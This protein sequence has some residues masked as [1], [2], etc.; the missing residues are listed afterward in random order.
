[1]ADGM[2]ALLVGGAIGVGGTILGTLLSQWMSRKTAVE[3][4]RQNIAGQAANVEKTIAAQLEVSQRTVDAQLEVSR[5]TV[6]TQ[7]A[8][9]QIVVEGQR[10]KE[11]DAALRDRRSAL[12]EPL[13]S[14]VNKRAGEFNNLSEAIALKDW[15]R[16][17]DL[18]VAL[19]QVSRVQQTLT[20]MMIINDQPVRRAVAAFLSAETDLWN[21][22]TQC[23]KTPHPDNNSLMGSAQADF[24]LAHAELVR[25]VDGFV[26]R[27]SDLPG[28]PI[29][30]SEI[31]PISSVRFAHPWIENPASP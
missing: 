4:A 7:L 3:V 14:G 28:N 9:A 10:L 31:V 24:V 5:R 30:I 1:M 16:A 15:G 20:E 2:A 27:P 13:I 18:F 25:V 21:T 11:R 29:D 19:G 23:L 17:R 22:Y 12:V 26:L 8:A 6:E